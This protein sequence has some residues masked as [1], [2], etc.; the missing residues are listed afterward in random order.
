MTLAEP[1][2]AQA[3]DG[4]ALFMADVRARARFNQGPEMRRAVEL[5]DR[6]AART[7]R[8]E[9]H[10]NGK[11]VQRTLLIASAVDQILRSASPGGAWHGKPNF[12]DLPD[13]LDELVPP[14][15]DENEPG[16]LAEKNQILDDFRIQRAMVEAR[17]NALVAQLES[18]AFLAEFNNASAATPLAD[19]P[20]YDAVAQLYYANQF[21]LYLGGT[22]AGMAYFKRCADF[23]VTL[24]APQPPGD[25][26]VFH[27]TRF[28]TF[29][30]FAPD[31][32]TVSGDHY[33][34]PAQRYNYDT[35][36]LLKGYGDG[37]VAAYLAFHAPVMAGLVQFARQLPSPERAWI[38]RSLILTMRAIGLH[39]MESEMAVLTWGNLYLNS[40]DVRNRLRAVAP[41][42]A[43]PATA[44][45]ALIGSWV[46]VQRYLDEPDPLKKRG[47]LL[48]TGKEI[49]A[50]GSAVA[51]TV[52]AAR[53][54]M[55]GKAFSATLTAWGRG[56]NVAAAAV[57]TVMNSQQLVIDLYRNP[58][59]LPATAIKLAGS[60][61]GLAAVSYAVFS[62]ASLAGPPGVIVAL[63]VMGTVLLGTFLEGYLADTYLEMFLTRGMFGRNQGLDFDPAE[64]F[65]RFDDLDMQLSAYLRLLL[66]M[67]MEGTAQT[68]VGEG[69][70]FTLAKLKFYSNY[71][72]PRGATFRMY[73]VGPARDPFSEVEFEVLG[74]SDTSNH[75]RG[76]YEHWKPHDPELPLPVVD[77]EMVCDR[78]EYSTLYHRPGDLR[79]TYVEAEVTMADEASILVLQSM[80]SAATGIPVR[81]L[82]MKLPMKVRAV[83]K[84]VAVG[85]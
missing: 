71:P 43:M 55:G 80:V 20:F 4:D 47:H 13:L 65:F 81:H 32:A 76:I 35:L 82:P 62:G 78:V 48:E 29:F 66:G 3:Q 36:G 77:D 26:P 60:T 79:N 41:I 12:P 56:L 5:K 16:G 73:Q 39:G 54:R 44:L 25:L 8:F 17:A 67:R 9:T 85:G 68:Q 15:E 61:V 52:Q 45:L 63:V 1:R 83:A 42:V 31:P 18:P 11:D 46:G 57:D 2:A 27:F 75:A 51:E 14:D 30:P 64:P 49:A 84:L 24:P 69:Q 37:V 21:S 10:L 6:L 33:D 19:A 58:D 74:P 59:Q 7:T 34:I 70:V 38:N 40:L 72:I 28:D 50:L 23:Q 53:H 22:A